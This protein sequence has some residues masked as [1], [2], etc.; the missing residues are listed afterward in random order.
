MISIS[1]IAQL[2]FYVNTHSAKNEHLSF[3][4]CVYGSVRLLCST[5]RSEAH[6]RGMA[7]VSLDRIRVRIELSSVS[8]HIL[9]RRRASV[10][11]SDI[12]IKNRSHKSGRVQHTR[13]S[14]LSCLLCPENALYRLIR[15]CAAVKS[16]GKKQSSDTH[17]T[18][19]LF[20]LELSTDSRHANGYPRAVLR[21][22][23]CSRVHNT[24]STIHSGSN[25]IRLGLTRGICLRVLEA[26]A[27]LS[28][29]IRLSQRGNGRE[30]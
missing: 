10:K 27:Y 20:S 29:S 13:P 4:C 15:D 26:S 18:S 21:V 14:D 8:L 11:C 19:S 30:R 24:S 22:Q 12:E 5:V 2:S 25:G 6:W 9:I 16:D 1:I 3:L 7:V 23:M 17:L 28:A